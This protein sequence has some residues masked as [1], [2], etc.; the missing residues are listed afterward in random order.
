MPKKLESLNAT[1]ADAFVFDMWGVLHDGT[2]AYDGVIDTLRALKRAGKKT[3]ILSNSP[4]PLFS[5]RE[6]IKKYGLVPDLYD[7]LLTSGQMT[8]EAL[9]K[10]DDAWLQKLGA[11]AY[12]IGKQEEAGFYDGTGITLVPEPE[13]ASFILVVNLPGDRYDEAHYRP[14][15]ERC[16]ARKLPMLCANPDRAV[17]VG[18]ACVPA[19]AALVDAYAAMGG[20]GRAP[21]GKPYGEAFARILA[22]LGIAPGRAVMVGDNL[23]TDIAGARAAG[24]Q[25]VLMPGGMYATALGVVNGAWPDEAKLGKLLTQHNVVPDYIMAA[26]RS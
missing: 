12:M 17:A 11:R 21:Y 4:R 23:E 13:D 15:L 5:A 7:A 24:M 3:G 22:E 19:S 9:Q 8:Y 10:R 14:L 20:D 18:A 2:R 26:L 25:S 1:G 16:L 6:N